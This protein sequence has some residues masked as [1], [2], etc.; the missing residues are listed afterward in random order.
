LPKA[1]SSRN[2][3]YFKSGRRVGGDKVQAAPSFVCGDTPPDFLVSVWVVGTFADIHLRV[4]KLELGSE[5]L[6]VADNS[7]SVGKNSEPLSVAEM[8]IYIL[9]FDF[10][11]LLRA[12]GQQTVNTFVFAYSQ[13]TILRHTPQRSTSF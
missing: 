9:L 5:L 3:Q 13:R 12:V 7:E 6:N 10:C 4:E 11:V 2:V 1:E 8:P